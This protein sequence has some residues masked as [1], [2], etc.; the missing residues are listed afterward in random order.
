MREVPM[1]QEGKSA[2]GGGGVFWAGVQRS[3]HTVLSSNAS[4]TWTYK[5]YTSLH[6]T[7]AGGRAEC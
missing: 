5:S 1:A 3:H 7:Q 2:L 6:P 4:K